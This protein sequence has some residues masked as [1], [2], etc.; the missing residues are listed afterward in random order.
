MRVSSDSNRELPLPESVRP[1]K[2]QMPPACGPASWIS[3]LMC[4]VSVSSASLSRRAHGPTAPIDAHHDYFTEQTLAES[5]VIGAADGA[6][7]KG[8]VEVG[9]VT[10]TLTLKRLG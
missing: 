8:D 4:A 10:L 5:F 2:I 7:A 1:Q 9:D 3:S 6:D